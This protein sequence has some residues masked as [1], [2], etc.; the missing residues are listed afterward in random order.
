[1]NSRFIL[2]TT[3]IWRVSSFMRRWTSVI[4]SFSTEFTRSQKDAAGRKL[5]HPFDP[6][7][8]YAM[9]GIN[10]HLLRSG[11]LFSNFLYVYFTWIYL[12]SGIGAAL[13]LLV[14]T[15]AALAVFL[16]AAGCNSDVAVLFTLCSAK[17]VKEGNTRL[18]VIKTER[19]HKV[20]HGRT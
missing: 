13:T 11:S 14:G 4:T 16:T 9:R 5:M 19:T 1:M 15:G 17:R 12:D 10:P 6:D 3:I 20:P 7:A 2:R 8:M 18:G